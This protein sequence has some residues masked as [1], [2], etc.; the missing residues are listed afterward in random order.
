MGCGPLANT[1]PVIKAGL[2]S[3]VMDS[4]A[5]VRFKDLNLDAGILG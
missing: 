3:D 4:G 2:D 5:H 1:A